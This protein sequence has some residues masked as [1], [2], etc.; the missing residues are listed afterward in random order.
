[1]W[2]YI[3]IPDQPDNQ[4]TFIHLLWFVFFVLSLGNP[5]HRV[6]Y[7][8]GWDPKIIIKA[9]LSTDFV[10]EVWVVFAPGISTEYIIS[11]P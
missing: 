3:P 11:M 1:M 8:T 7:W 10:F 9:A 6:C 4:L 2:V 5:S